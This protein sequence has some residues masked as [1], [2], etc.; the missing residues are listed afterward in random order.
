MSVDV[1]KIPYVIIGLGVTGL[2]AARF[3]RSKGVDFVVMD[4][5]ENPPNLDE[6]LKEFAQIPMTLGVLNQEH[7]NNAEEIIVSPG[8]SVQLPELQEAAE[9]GAKLIGDAELFSRAVKAPVVAVTGSNAK[10]TVV[11]LVGEMIKAEG[12]RVA[13]VGNIG[14]PML[15]AVNDD[16]DFY[17]VELSSFQLETTFSLKAEVATILNLSEDHMD[18]YDSMVEYH[19]AKQRIYQGAKN[20]V[21]NRHDKFTEPQEGNVARQYS[22]GLDNPD[23]NGFGKL[24]QADQA[25]LVFEEDTLMPVSE[26]FLRGLHNLSNILASMALGYCIG[27]SIKSMVKVASSFSGLPHRCQLVRQINGI[28]FINDS[29]ATNVGAASAALAGFSNAKEKIILIAG[30]ESKDADFSPLKTLVSELVKLVI[31]IGKDA[32]KIALSLS[33]NTEKV[34]VETMNDAVKLARKKASSGDVVLLSP[35]CASFDMFSGFEERGDVFVQAV[36]ELEQ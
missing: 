34:F 16:V 26:V 13:V 36:K 21:I 23:K 11:T 25:Y 5:R 29:K 19:Q 6:F 8:L 4:T 12:Y 9:H 15:D 2:S 14:Q 10:S 7:L 22:F 30:G 31:L 17:V 32:K 3:L 35:A 20:I 28:D 1:D 33:E 24:D 18:R 27:L